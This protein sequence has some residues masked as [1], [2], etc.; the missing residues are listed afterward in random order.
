MAEGQRLAL[1]QGRRIEVGRGFGRR[2]MGR[3]ASA[4]CCKGLPPERLFPAGSVL[5]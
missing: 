3:R 5:V 1:S 2:H 4:A